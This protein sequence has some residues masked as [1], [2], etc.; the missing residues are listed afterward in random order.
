MPSP[1]RRVTAFMGTIIFTVV[2]P[3]TFCGIFPRMIWRSL[4]AITGVEAWA[5]RGV[6]AIGILI[7]LFT[8]FWSFAIVSGGTPAPVFPTQKLVVFGLHRYVRNPMYIGV[9]LIILG[10]AWL[11]HSLEI[12]LYLLVFF[13]AA[14]LFVRFYEEPA[15]KKQ[16][17]EEY[18]R[19]KTDVPRWI[20][21]IRF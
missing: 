9:S 4:T 6:I 7:Y 3:F 5:A 13:S 19:Y 16:F 20:P 17:G 11:F 8:A 12:F 21:K 14:A 1:Q 15:L 2:A 10:Q 18:E